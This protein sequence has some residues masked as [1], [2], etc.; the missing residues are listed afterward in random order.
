MSL[1]QEKLLKLAKE[2]N[3]GV[4]DLSRNEFKTYAEFTKILKNT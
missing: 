2:S 3:Q 1:L 4:K